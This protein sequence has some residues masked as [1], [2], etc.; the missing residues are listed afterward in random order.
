M[1]KPIEMINTFAFRSSVYCLFQVTLLS[2]VCLSCNNED[3]SSINALDVKLDLEHTINDK[4]INSSTQSLNRYSSTLRNLKKAYFDYSSQEKN[5]SVKLTDEA[6]QFLEIRNVDIG[7]VVPLLP[8]S[9]VNDS[10]FDIAN[11]ILAE[12]S[13][14]GIS[15]PIQKSNQSF[16][17]IDHSPN[18]FNDKGEYVFEGGEYKPNPGVL[19]KRINLVNNCLR[20]RLWELGA[21]DAVGEMYHAWVE[22]DESTYYQMLADQSGLSINSI[23]KDF[24]NPVYFDNVRLDLGLLCAPKKDVG[25]YPVSYNSDKELGSYSSQDSRRKVQRKFYNIKR[26]DIQLEARYQSELKDGDKFSMFTFEEPGIYNPQVRNE[27]TFERKWAT[28][29]ISFVEPKTYYSKTQEFLPSEYLQI[30]LFDEG[31]NQSMVI[32]NIPMALLSFK[33]DFVIPSFGVGVLMASELIERRLLR[34][35]KGPRPSFAYLTEFREN[36]HYIQNNHAVGLEQIFLRPIQKEDGVYLRCTV[37]SY[38]RI[39]DLLEFEILIPELEQTFLSNNESYSPPIF[40]TY[41]DDNTL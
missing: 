22:L 20:P 21:N 13:R 4:T 24:D 1:N 6:D 12:Y 34:K 39:T 27:L 10:K 11:V 17:T 8:Y 5:L 28:A 30:T 40:E 19:P 7:F 32:G 15:I 36:D 25:I 33:N 26:G 2:L 14:N 23:P 16:A 18:L 41:Q 38:E 3:Q 9:G 31:R 37:V 35:E 29:E